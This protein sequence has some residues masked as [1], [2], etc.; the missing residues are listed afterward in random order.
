MKHLLLIL[1]FSFGIT[2]C[3]GGGQ[4]GGVKVNRGAERGKQ[5]TGGDPATGG[6][7]TGASVN[8]NKEQKLWGKAYVAQTN[9]EYTTDYKFRFNDNLKGLVSAN[10]NE[11]DLGD[12]NGVLLDSGVNTGLYFWG[13]VD[14]AG[15][16]VQP[17]GEL[18]LSIIDDKVGTQVDGKTVGEIPIYLK[19]VTGTQSLTQETVNLTF[20]DSYGS[21]TLNG[22]LAYHPNYQAKVY[23]GSISYNNNV[24]FNSN[25]PGYKAQIGYFMVPACGF[26]KNL[27]GCTK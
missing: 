2:A 15:G 9:A 25:L 19:S 1:A 6:T 5:P 18:R 21:I 27:Q 8:Y 23:F 13:Q 10:M 20:S 22:K 3:G 4:K 24:T 16:Q 12:V 26:F 11:S 17:N 14:L 7:P